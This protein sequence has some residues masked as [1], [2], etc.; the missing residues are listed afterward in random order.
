VNNHVVKLI[1]VAFLA[2]TL[3]GCGGGNRF[4]SNRGGQV[5][6]G[7]LVLKDI[8]RRPAQKDYIISYGD[9]LDV[10]FLYD[11]PLNQSALKVRPDGKISLPHVGEIAVAGM[12]ISAL[13][14]LLA[15]RYS[16]ILV[17]PSVTAILHDFQAPV[18]YIMGD[19]NVPGG[20]PFRSGMTLLNALTLSG[21]PLKTA[22]KSGVLVIR[23]IGPDHIV[24]IQIDLREI[25]DKKRFDLDIPIEPL[26]IVFVPKSKLSSA[27]D[28][29]SVVSDL[30]IKPSD[31]Y[32]RGWE[33]ANVKVLY[34]FYR[35]SGNPY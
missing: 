23:R 11:T 15:A 18:V 10:V 20:Y 13:D 14:S 16:E 6:S 19:V 35:H 12:P 8:P 1:A 21:G 5:E 30:L 31:V 34:D 9:V 7:E 29:V 28:F 3:G 25:L 32:L 17:D 26:D 27:E 33:V 24:G 2:V 4:I 22:R